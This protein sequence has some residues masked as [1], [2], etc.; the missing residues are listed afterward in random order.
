MMK[1][2]EEHVYGQVGGNLVVIALC[3]IVPVLCVTD[4]LMNLLLS[5]SSSSSSYLGRFFEFES[6]CSSPEL[7]RLFGAPWLVL[8]SSSLALLYEA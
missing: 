6:F 5:S 3:V 1:G 8:P 7:L 2:E 4:I